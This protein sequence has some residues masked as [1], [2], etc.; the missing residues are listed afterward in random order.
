[1]KFELELLPPSMPNFVSVKTPPRPR[2]EGLKPSLSLDNHL[3]FNRGTQLYLWVWSHYFIDFDD[4]HMISLLLLRF[5]GL[6]R[7]VCKIEKR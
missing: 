6:I 7:K 5:D 2:Q 1:M 3:T 4:E